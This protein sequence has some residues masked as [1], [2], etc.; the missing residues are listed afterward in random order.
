MKFTCQCHIL[1]T[2]YKWDVCNL[3]HLRITL[4]C[5]VTISVIWNICK[6]VTLWSKLLSSG[7]NTYMVLVS[8]HQSQIF[9]TKPV[10]YHTN[11]SLHLKY[12]CD[13]F[14]LFYYQ[15]N[16]VTYSNVVVYEKVISVK[17]SFYVPEFW[18]FC[19]LMNFVLS[20]HN[21]RKNYISLALHSPG[22]YAILSSPHRNAK[23]WCY[24]IH[25]LYI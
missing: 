7:N 12:F 1:W 4:H 11:R 24:H 22:F 13:L 23:S 19:K 17:S 20:Q 8:T 15:R 10:R 14:W 18:V 5:Y 25:F 21:A 16:S 3:H 9:V 2:E 6:W